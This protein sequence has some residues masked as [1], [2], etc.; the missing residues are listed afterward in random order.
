ME[1]IRKRQNTCPIFKTATKSII[2]AMT[3]AS[4]LAGV[5]LHRALASATTEEELSQR[6]IGLL[7]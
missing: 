4:D 3:I 1:G 5:L 6:P 2:R 7:S